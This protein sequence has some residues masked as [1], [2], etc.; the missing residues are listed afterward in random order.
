MQKVNPFFLSL[1]SQCPIK[2]QFAQQYQKNI[3]ID[4]KIIRDTIQSTF[5]YQSKNDKFATWRL[6]TTWTQRNM[7]KYMADVKDKKNI[8]GSITIL[9]KL[10]NWYNNIYLEQ[11]EVD[12]LANVPIILNLGDKVVYRDSID[13]MTNGTELKLFNFEQ[14]DNASDYK[15]QQMFN[16]LETLIQIWGFWKA[17]EFPPNKLVKI[18]NTPKTI[19]YRYKL[20]DQK[21]LHHTE[22]IVGYLLTG[23]INH[24]YY[25]NYSSQCDKCEFNFICT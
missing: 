14:V 22:K 19:Q 21:F 23:V 15:D 25:Q 18:I 5:M 12:T 16:E 11:P 20:I 13:I 8:K 24:V 1:Y 2:A 3:P 17:T 10:F 4:L 6:V 9:E 7:V